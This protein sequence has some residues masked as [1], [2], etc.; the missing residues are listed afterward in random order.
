MDFVWEESL[1]KKTARMIVDTGN[2]IL[3][4][5]IFTMATQLLR[6]IAKDLLCVQLVPNCLWS[7]SGEKMNL[8][9]AITLKL[10]IGNLEIHS[11]I[12]WLISVNLVS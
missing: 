8:L 2:N 12:T 9:G 1:K 7:V 10:E 3:V 5:I 4:E 11:R 6:D